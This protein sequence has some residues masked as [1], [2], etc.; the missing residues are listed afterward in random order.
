MK[1]ET[2]S[3]S[4][5]VRAIRSRSIGRARVIWSELDYAQQRLFEVQTGLRINRHTAEIDDLERLYH[6]RPRSF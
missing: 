5:R 4:G 6:W 2:T 1:N 3:L